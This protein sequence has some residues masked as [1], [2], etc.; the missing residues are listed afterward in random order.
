[1]TLSLATGADLQATA[2]DFMVRA[3]VAADVAAAPVWLALAEGRLNRE[4]GVV[5]TDTTLTGVA[6]SRRIDIS[7]LSMVQPIALFLAETGMKEREVQ[8]KADGTFPYLDTEGRPSFAAI[9]GT[10]IDFDCPLSAAYPFRLRYRQRFALTDAGTNWLL[11]NHPDI[12]LA[13]VLMWGAG[14]HQDWANGSAWKAVLDEGI[15]SVR[16]TIAQNKRGTL[17]VDPG[18]VATGGGRSLAEW[19]SDA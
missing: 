19:T 18:L 2:L 16:H 5:E 13:A 4:L 7:S 9:D 11:T 1:M 14:Y 15:P 12:Y 17:T 3:G 6:S 10:N 8:F